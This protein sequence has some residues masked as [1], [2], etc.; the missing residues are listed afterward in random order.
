MSSAACPARGMG[1]ARRD[2]GPASSAVATQPPDRRRPAARNLEARAVHFARAVQARGLGAHAVL[3][4]CSP[5]VPEPNP[6]ISPAEANTT[7][8]DAAHPDEE[9]TAI[10]PAVEVVEPPAAVEARAPSPAV[11]RG[12]DRNVDVDRP[13]QIGKY[14]LLDRL[15]RGSFGV[16]YSARDPNLERNIA[17]K[18][19]RLRHLTNGDIVQ[20]FLQ[21]AR[22]TARVAHP[23][24]VT[25]YDCG[26]VE[27]ARGPTAFIAMELLSGE[28]LTKRL[29]RSGRLAPEL[30]AEIGRQVASALEAAHRV[31]V[32]HR[33]LKPDII[34]L[35]ADPAMPSGERVKVLD[36]GLAKLGAGGN[37]QVQN[38]F[39]TPRYMSP[40]QCRSTRAVDHRGDIYALGCILFELVTGHPPFQ[41]DVRQ[42]LRAQ[43]ITTPPRARSIVPACPV[44]FD[45][46]IAE[47]LAKD[48]AARPRSMAAV[49]SAL[50]PAAALQLA[51]AEPVRVF[52]PLH[53]VAA[54]HLPSTA[55]FPVAAPPPAAPETAAPGELVAPPREISEPVLP[56][57]PASLSSSATR[58]AT[59]LGHPAPPNRSIISFDRDDGWVRRTLRDYALLPPA[60]R[61]RRLVQFGALSAVVVA[62]AV[63]AALITS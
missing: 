58:R 31:D 28:S 42:V 38:V 47:M 12:T 26:L 44:E 53:A 50:A 29:A 9:P 60:C 33:D 11:A 15:G 41:G 37:T 51:A 54:A 61:H 4:T 25:V 40:E 46:L 45:Q 5:G 17:I 21:E 36:F 52:P 20:R 34:Y 13:G 27:A 8:R 48:P 14:E 56:A 57:D 22:A 32:L 18:V 59:T 49:Q 10:R 62:L 63:A 1:E 3:P 23:G 55:A 16:V 35:V 6:R 30:A 43:Q 7:I 19:L 39:G 24:I 2:W